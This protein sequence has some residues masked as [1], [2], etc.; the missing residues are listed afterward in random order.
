MQMVAIGATCVHKVIAI[1]RVK[2][3]ALTQCGQI[4]DLASDHVRDGRFEEREHEL[5]L[6]SHCPDRWPEAALRRARWRC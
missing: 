5:P 1:N 3:L 6:C 2:L 4:Y